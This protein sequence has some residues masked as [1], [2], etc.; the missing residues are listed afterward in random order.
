[1]IFKMELSLLLGVLV[2]LPEFPRAGGDSNCLLFVVVAIV[3][4]TFSLYLHLF[5]FDT[6]GK[7]QRRHVRGYVFFTNSIP[8]Y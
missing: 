1:M 5:R 3:V 8:C 6:T 2:I 4:V 7:R